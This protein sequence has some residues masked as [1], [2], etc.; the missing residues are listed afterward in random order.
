MQPR[1]QTRRGRERA[2]TFLTGTFLGQGKIIPIHG[3]GTP[4][5][6]VS[7]LRH[8]LPLDERSFVHPA[9][10]KCRQRLRCHARSL[11]RGWIGHQSAA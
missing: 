5:Q 10:I 6:Q 1:K 3:I 8:P 2:E 9:A 11:M 4:L 7:P